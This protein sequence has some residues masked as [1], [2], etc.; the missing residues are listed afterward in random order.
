MTI[1]DE[2]L[3]ALKDEYASG[4][5]QKEIGE[6]HGLTQTDVQ[7]LLSG[8]RKVDGLKLKTFLR[9]FP[10]ASINLNGNTVNVRSDNGS[11]AFGVVAGDVNNVGQIPRELIS[12][13]L[14]D[15]SL[16]IAERAQLLKELYK[17]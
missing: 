8:D 6:K 16:S 9:M 2:I 1:Q 5:T 15:K 10:N 17:K 7:R 13:V 14:A 12:A 11:T 4:K 3:A